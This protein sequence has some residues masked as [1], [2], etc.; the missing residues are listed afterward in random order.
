M[1]RVGRQLRVRRALAKSAAESPAQRGVLSERRRAA[2]AARAV[3]QRRVDVAQHSGGIV[4]HRQCRAGQRQWQS[5]APLRVGQQRRR[6]RRRRR[7]RREFPL[8]ILTRQ[9][10]HIGLFQIQKS[11]LDLQNDNTP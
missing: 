9:Q 2:K 4:D 3:A 11:L 5:V 6:R 10:V 1:S 8:L 7:P